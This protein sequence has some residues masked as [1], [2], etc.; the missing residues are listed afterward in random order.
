[1]GQGGRRPTIS[2]V[3]GRSPPVKIQR[4]LSSGRPGSAWKVQG[5]TEADY[6]TLCNFMV[7]AGLA[8]EATSGKGGGKGGFTLKKPEAEEDLEHVAAALKVWFGV[9]EE[10][11]KLF[12]EKM[13]TA[14]V[15]NTFSKSVF[16]LVMA[17]VNSHGSYTEGKRVK[18]EQKV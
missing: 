3:W 11:V 1:V 17:A 7:A 4:E 10:G 14:D 8:D 13:K 6:R 2:G 12:V 18:V 9:Q 15:S 5:S 16:D